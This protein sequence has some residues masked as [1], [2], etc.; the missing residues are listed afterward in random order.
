[1]ISLISSLPGPFRF[2]E[3]ISKRPKR[4]EVGK[5]RARIEVGGGEP[6]I[7]WKEQGSRGGGVGERNKQRK[8]REGEGCL[9]PIAPV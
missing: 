1:M 2:G 8:R 4:D 6:G 9:A 7:S 5:K 3:H